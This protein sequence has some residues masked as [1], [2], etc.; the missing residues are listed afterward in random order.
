MVV[1]TRVFTRVAMAP[2]FNWSEVLSLDRIII[3]DLCSLLIKELLL[4]L[5]NF[6]FKP[7]SVIYL[8]TW[9]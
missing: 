2:V 6:F 7:A 8:E 1:L 5:R 9:V 4:W 3:Y